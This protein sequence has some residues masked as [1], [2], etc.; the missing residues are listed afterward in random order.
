MTRMTLYYPTWTQ[1]GLYSCSVFVAETSIY[2][3][4]LKGKRGEYLALRNL[5]YSSRRWVTPLIDIIAPAKPRNSEA[6]ERK[7]TSLTTQMRRHAKDIGECWKYAES[8]VFVDTQ[9]IPNSGQALLVL[10]ELMKNYC[11]VPTHGPG[12]GDS[13]ADAVVDVVKRQPERGAC[14]RV[15]RDKLYDTDLDNHFLDFIRRCEVP[16]S[17][18]DVLIDFESLS[19]EPDNEALMALIG[20]INSFPN[21]QELR[22][23]TLTGGSF[24]VDLSARQ[25][26]RSEIT[27][28]EWKMWQTLITGKRLARQ[29][30]FGDYGIQ[31]P[32]SSSA[33][34]LGKA[35]IRYTDAKVW[36]VFRGARVID[37][38]DAK[39]DL[40]AEMKPL[41]VLAAKAK[42]FG[43]RDYSWADEYIHSCAGLETPAN[44]A[45]KWKAVGFNHHM[46]YV[47]NQLRASS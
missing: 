15:P 4:V 27:R 46:T 35:N 44:D 2:V 19:T 39:H 34:F 36:I 21:L 1:F 37:P 18:V 11:I 13:C 42:E 38:K 14:Y 7:P 10:C 26:G 45:A 47:V 6:A 5:L 32:T 17:S 40:P 30:R 28:I 43:G 22:S 9:L 23:L 8:P 29:P 31:N 16:A 33:G 20:R 41:C 24:P 25:S 12:R 3:P